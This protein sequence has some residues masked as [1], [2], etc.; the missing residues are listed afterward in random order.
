MFLQISDIAGNLIDKGSLG[1]LC[2]I[3][4]SAVIA[5]WWKIGDKDKIILEQGK[6][7]TKTANS[8]V[9]VLDVISETTKTLPET[10]KEK[11]GPMIKDS[12]ASLK[13]VI[14]NESNR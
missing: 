9:G 14:R 3:L 13:E 2:L 8:L 4:M 5:L 12:T 11:L 7:M 10:I 6:E 1:L